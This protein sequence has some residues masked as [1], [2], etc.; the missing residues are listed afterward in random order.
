MVSKMRILTIT[1]PLLPPFVRS[2]FQKVSGPFFVW[3]T[4]VENNFPDAALHAQGMPA[5]NAQDFELQNPTI[6]VGMYQFWLQ[7]PA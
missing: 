3:T 2:I 5:V 1:H 4:L 6:F 7:K